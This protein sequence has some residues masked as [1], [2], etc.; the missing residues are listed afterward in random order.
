MNFE[1]QINSEYLIWPIKSLRETKK[2]V[3][4]IYTLIEISVG[5][6]ILKNTLFI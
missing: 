2:L 1:F 3:E 5:V 6:V 4:Y